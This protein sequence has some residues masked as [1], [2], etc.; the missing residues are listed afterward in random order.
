MTTAKTGERMV[1]ELY[2]SEADYILYLRHL[3]AYETAG[4]R[5]RSSDSVLDIGCGTGYGTRML[6]G[7]AKQATGVD[8]SAETV[9]AA[10]AG[11]GSGTCAFAVYDGARLPFGDGV[12]D[13]ATSF[14]TIEH[15]QDDDRFVAEAARVLKPGA[16]LVLTTP[17]R[18]T[19]LREGQ[20]PWNRFHVREYSAHQLEALLTRHF[21]VVE[22]MGVRANTRMEEVERAR[23][24]SAQRLA[25]LDPLGLR[26]FA[27]P[28]ADVIARL[29]STPAPA[30]WPHQVADFYATVEDRDA[31]CDL[32]AICRR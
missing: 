4:S 17:N 29:R 26:R 6:A 9:A 12:F 8:V 1:P 28:L 15:V 22:V 11:Y 23:V 2:R 21:A 31:G 16:L 27:A 10:T 32:L 18:A 5:L 7:H 13:A 25:N 14:Q 3:F 19:R 24:A 20:R 30:S